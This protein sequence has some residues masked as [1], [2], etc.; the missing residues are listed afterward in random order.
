M[1]DLYAFGLIV[2]LPLLFK[3]IFVVS[4]VKE[5]VSEDVSICLFGPMNSYTVPIIQKINK[6]R[7]PAIL[8]VN[9]LNSIPIPMLHYVDKS[10]YYKFIPYVTAGT[11]NLVVDT[12]CSL[13][14]TSIVIH[15]TAFVYGNKTVLNPSYYLPSSQYS[16]M[17][18][19][20]KVWSDFQHEKIK[21]LVMIPYTNGTYHYIEEFIHDIIRWNL[22]IN[23]DWYTM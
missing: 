23:T 8:G 3:Y 15:D 13:S 11:S 9:S 20:Q 21:G 10:N 7:V 12:V 1:N 2:V 18:L 5:S 22:T 14:N 16:G 17:E 19:M 6:L 4:G